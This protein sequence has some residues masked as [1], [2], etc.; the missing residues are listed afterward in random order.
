ML[1][2][3]N[4]LIQSLPKEALKSFASDRRKEFAFY[5]DIEQ[6]NIAFYFADAYSAWK[7]G[8]NENSN[9]LLRVFFLNA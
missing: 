5:S 8:N 1:L 3:V 6:Q 7:R 2:V 4:Q 9:R